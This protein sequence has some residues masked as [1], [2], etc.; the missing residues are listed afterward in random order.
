MY[1]RRMVCRNK[2]FKMCSK[3][4]FFLFTTR[5]STV[6]AH[7]VVDHAY[8]GSNFSCKRIRLES[9][10]A[11][12]MDDES[13]EPIPEEDD[14]YRYIR[15]TFSDDQSQSF[16]CVINGEVQFDI[17]KFWFSTEIKKEF[18]LLSRVAV[19]I[20]SIPASSA[21]SERVFSTAGRIL[22]KRR[23]RLSS[24]SVDC[25]LFLHSKHN[26]DTQ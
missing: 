12:W 25:L 20:L 21:S 22:E 10:V 24:S 5:T 19:G 14:V 17:A 15:K 4:D 18:P 8:G 2:P 7:A 3:C 23:N 9:E 6:S 13:D 16:N 11:D 1:T 26:A